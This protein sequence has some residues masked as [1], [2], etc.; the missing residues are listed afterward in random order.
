MNS[1]LGLSGFSGLSG[2]SDRPKMKEPVR[3]HAARALVLPFLGVLDA[4]HKLGNFVWVNGT[5][6]DL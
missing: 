4:A 5:T 6:H 1:L 3:Q 2:Q